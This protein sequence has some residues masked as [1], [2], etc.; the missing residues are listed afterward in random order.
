MLT[1]I[2]ETTDEYDFD[3][4]FKLTTK[5]SLRALEYQDDFSINKFTMVK[6]IKEIHQ[7]RQMDM[8]D[9]DN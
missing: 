6:L 7:N 5:V 1:T 4:K 2:N 8:Y 9:Q 3:L